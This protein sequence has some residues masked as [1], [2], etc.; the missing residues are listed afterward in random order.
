MLDLLAAWLLYPLVALLVCLGIGLLLGAVVIGQW[1]AAGTGE[2]SEARLAVFGATV[3][4]IG[5]QVFFASFL[6]SI[7]GLRR[8]R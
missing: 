4:I 8:T 3:M 1:I 5:V 7:L 2:I 6:L